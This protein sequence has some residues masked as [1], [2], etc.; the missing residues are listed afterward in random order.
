MKALDKSVYHDDPD[1]SA[2]K[3]AFRGE[4]GSVEDF[5]K[6]LGESG[7]PVLS[8]ALMRVNHPYYAYP[9]KNHWEEPVWKMHE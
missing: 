5:E 4:A 8:R 7:D 6:K 9:H 2:A 3:A 1:H